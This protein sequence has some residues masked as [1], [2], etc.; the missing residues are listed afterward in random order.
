MPKPPSEDDTDFERR[1]NAKLA[2]RRAED[3]KRNASP[4][5]WALGMRYGTEF[6]AGVLVGAA[7]GYGADRLFGWSPFG[8]LAG[9]L[10]GFAAGTLNV[11]RAAAEVN[12]GQSGESSDKP[13]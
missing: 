7:L 13:Q 3:A 2:A 12:A 10:L 5:G 1:L 4:N 9:V 8:I 11:V 6:A